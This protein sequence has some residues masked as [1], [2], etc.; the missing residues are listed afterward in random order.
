MFLSLSSFSPVCR[1][2]QCHHHY[3]HCC[4]N[5]ILVILN[6]ISSFFHH[7]RKRSIHY[8]SSLHYIVLSSFNHEFIIRIAIL[9]VSNLLL[10]NSKSVIGPPWLTP[11]HS[12]FDDNV[13]N[14]LIAILIIFYLLSF[15]HFCKSNTIFIYR[16]HQY[17]QI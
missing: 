7:H 10:T 4:M 9:F 13:A 5:A 6:V 14:H 11:I 15:L 2:Y 17:V 8:C 1:K 12:L 16:K 3:Y